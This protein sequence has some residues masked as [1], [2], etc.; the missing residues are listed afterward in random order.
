MFPVNMAKPIGFF[1]AQH[2]HKLL[3]GLKLFYDY[4]LTKRAQH[5]IHIF[6]VFLFFFFLHEKLRDAT[7]PDISRL[8]EYIRM[9][10]MIIN[11]HQFAWKEQNPAQANIPKLQRA[12][13]VS[14]S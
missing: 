10:T 6:L 14:I 12:E 4:K 9:M 1:F 3:K 2:F 7:G 13:S 8:G 11:N 5:F